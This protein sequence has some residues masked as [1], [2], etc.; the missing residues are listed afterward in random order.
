MAR[1]E[2]IIKVREMDAEEM[3]KSKTHQETNPSD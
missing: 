3:Q 2:C 1:E